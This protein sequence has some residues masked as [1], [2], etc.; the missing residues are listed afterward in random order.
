MSYG[1]SLLRE[2]LQLAVAYPL[3]ENYRPDWLHGLEL[4]FY[5]PDLKFG[6]EFQGDQHFMDTK[7]FGSCDS[8]RQRDWRKR[9]LCKEA[10]VILQQFTAFDLQA[11]RVRA[12]LKWVFKCLNRKRCFKPGWFGIP[13]KQELRELSQR[14]IAYRKTLIGHFDSPTCRKRGSSRAKAFA[15]HGHYRCHHV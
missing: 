7:D 12:K 1:Q 6:V 10:G 15:R 5:F 8:Q 13:H 9:V 14:A 3:L 2:F 4:D 11:Q